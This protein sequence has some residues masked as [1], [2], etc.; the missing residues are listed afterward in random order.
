MPFRTSILYR[1]PQSFLSALLQ[2]EQYVIVTHFRPDG[3][4]LGSQIAM[5]LFL[6]KLGKRITMLGDILPRNLKWIGKHGYRVYVESEEQQERIRSADAVVVLDAGTLNRLGKIGSAVAEHPTRYLIDHHPDPADDFVASHWRTS[7]SSTG[8]LIY[9]LITAHDADLINR[10]I[11]TAL[12]VA[13]MTDTGSFRFNSV[14]P[15]VHEIT[16]DLLHRGELNPAP[17]HD[18]IFSNNT[19]GG[20][21]LLGEALRSID[22]HFDGKVATMIV[23]QHML[24][25]TGT[26]TDE[27]RGFVNHALSV[28]GAEVGVLFTEL[29]GHVKISFRSEGDVAV[30]GWAA[31]FGGGGHRNASGA[32]VEGRLKKVVW[33][34]LA[35]A[36]DYLDY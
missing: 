25:E 34:V 22:L 35:A 13:I 1:M 20:L 6:R 28:E 15:R 4:A 36:G 30:N 8:E 27:I 9:E 23:T 26:R 10:D 29:K 24:E 33:N 7:A 11:A 12:Y 16:A 19:L 32:Y 5:G 17:I 31:H 2:H 21:H 18:A 14:T 3:D